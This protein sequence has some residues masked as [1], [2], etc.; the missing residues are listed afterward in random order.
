LERRT[1]CWEFMECGREPGGACASEEGICPAATF[2]GYDGVNSGKNAG[3]I[4]W[5]VAGTLS[6]DQWQGTYARRYEDCA[7]CRFLR[8]VAMEEKQFRVE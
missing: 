6:N 2:S 7:S 3:R 8:L 5:I 1:N 4:C